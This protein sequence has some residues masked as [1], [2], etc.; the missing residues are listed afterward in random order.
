MYRI[1][2]RRAPG[3]VE[4]GSS[5]RCYCHEA[6]FPE[7]YRELADRVEQV[8]LELEGDDGEPVEESERWAIIERLAN[9]VIDKHGI[10]RG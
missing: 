1:L 2:Q 10:G 8:R 3:M 6:P 5:D 4:L 9:E 7:A